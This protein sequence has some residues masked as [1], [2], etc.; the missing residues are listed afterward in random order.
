MSVDFVIFDCDGVLVD[1]EIITSAT[2]A[3]S[4]S[5]RGLA[6]DTASVAARFRGGKMKDVI[7]AA[8]AEL[9]TPLGEDFVPQFRARLFERLGAEVQ[10]I[11]GIHAALDGI[12][13]LGLPYCVASNG[14]RAKME[15]TLGAT[16]LLARFEGKI[17]SA[18]EVG[19]Y[20][21]DPGL[22]LHAAASMGAEP[23]RCVV[24][25]D[26]ENGLAAV[27]A[28][29]MH[30]VAYVGHGTPMDTTNAHALQDMAKLPDLLAELRGA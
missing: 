14:P 2:I 11:P 6:W 30:A 26:T 20:K 5:A 7:N 29:G 1:S 18:Y 9:G 15:T 27:H 8:E 25:E 21:P 3:E 4:V 19:S 24:V 23:T 22:F 17:H 16:D 28:A 12:E 13:A 10:A